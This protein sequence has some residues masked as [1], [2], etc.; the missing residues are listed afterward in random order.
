VLWGH[1]VLDG[2]EG[3]IINGTL[4]FLRVLGLMAPLYN[5]RVPTIAYV[6]EV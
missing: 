5:Y 4:Y 3:V 1:E 6:Q 2:K